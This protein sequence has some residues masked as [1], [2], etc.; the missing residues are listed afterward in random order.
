MR[1]NAMPRRR[2]LTAVGAVGFAGAAGIATTSTACAAPPVAAPH[3]AAPATHHQAGLMTLIGSYTSA[4]PPGRGL[5]V[6]IR[7]EAGVLEPS[8]VVDGV[9][10]ASFF[11]WSPDHK[12]L[13]VTNEIPQ[14]TITAV[15]LSAHHPVVLNSRPSGGAGPTHIAMH[16]SGEFL[17][18]A[19]YTDGTV[20]VHRRNADGSIGES[21]DLVKHPGSQPHAHQVLV[22]P[23]KRWVVAVDLGADAVFV[24]AFDTATGKLTQ[25]QHLEL[26]TGTGP[27][28]LA[29]NYTRAY[30]LAELK[31]EITVLDWDPEAGRFTPGQVVGTREPD[32]SGENFPA[33]IAISR[34]A[35]FAYASNRGDDNIATF[36]IDEAGLTFRGTT[37]TGGSWPRHFA[38]D[39]EQTSLFVANQRAGTITRLARDPGT[40]VL[41]PTQDSYACP[42]VAAITFHG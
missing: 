14:G 21:T 25:H 10:D 15:D 13:Y 31:S 12:F 41:T 4:N 42:S 22:D 24:Y 9:P 19:N 27:R 3:P 37:P 8:G 30:L 32:A 39:P 28:H 34:D 7:D 36:A 40:G 2:F 11:A 6:A 35:K 20:A 33:E 18:T 5:E 29:F 17:F 38:L 23:T 1:D 26:P 16:P